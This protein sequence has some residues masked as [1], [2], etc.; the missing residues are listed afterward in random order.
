M[1]EERY[2]EWLE[3]LDID[4]EETTR[5]ERLQWALRRE[6]GYHPSE[7]QIDAAWKTVQVVWEELAPRGVRPVQIRYPWG[8]DLR[9]VVSGR[10]GLF[11][12][13]SIKEMFGIET[14]WG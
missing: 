9:F 8:T 6:L 3:R 5:R 4:V 12:W 11:G 14:P 1:T 7:A 13:Q 10:R 2:I